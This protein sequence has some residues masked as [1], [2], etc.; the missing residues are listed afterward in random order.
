[1]TK[2][3][4][5]MLNN[6]IVPKFENIPNISMLQTTRLGGVSSG[7]Y[8]TFNLSFNNDDNNDD[9]KKNFQKLEQIVPKIYWIN[10]SHSDR[11]I[12]L[13]SKDLDGDA[14]FTYEKNLVCAV[15]T[16]D[17]LPILLANKNGTMVAAI[18]VG[19]RGLGLGIIEKTLDIIN[20]DSEIYA[21]LGPSIGIEQFIVGSD[22]YDFFKKNDPKILN[23]F[24]RYHDKY[25]LCLPTAAKY[26]L[27]NK[28]VKKIFGSTIDEYFCTYNDD[29]RFFSYRRDKVTGRMA[30]L[31]WIN[32]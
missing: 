31:I 24:T 30:S 11:V 4:T 23:S 25:K 29:K 13:P 6:F 21:W 3:L 12:K 14:V 20:S 10:Q 19:W 26:K 32:N 2:I 9:V 17:C 8:S 18:H 16:A 28:G 22:V 5:K 1:M 7:V 15:R 27:I